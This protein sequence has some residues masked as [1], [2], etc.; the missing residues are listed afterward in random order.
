MYNLAIHPYGCRVIQRILEHCPH[1][2]TSGILSQIHA[3][4][5]VLIVDQYGNYVI[6][7]VLQHGK[8]DDISIVIKHVTGKVHMVWYGMVWYG[9][10][11]ASNGF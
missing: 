3:S 6:Q 4:I 11:A 10:V 1:E 7:H 9:M 8:P 5:E 2:Q